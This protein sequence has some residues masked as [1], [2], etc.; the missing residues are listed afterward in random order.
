[1]TAPFHGTK[2]ALCIALSFSIYS[3]PYAAFA[4]PVTGQSSFGGGSTTATSSPSTSTSGGSPFG[5][6]SSISTGKPS[7]GATGDSPFG[8]SGS[9]SGTS[10]PP[11]PADQAPI[12]GGTPSTATS[13]PPATS[14]NAP[15][16]GAQTPGT[17][18][19]P[20]ASTVRND[21]VGDLK[22]QVDFAQTHVVAS[23]RRIF[24]PFLV[25]GKEA[26]VLFT[27][28]SSLAGVNLVVELDG[29]RHEFRMN[30]PSDMPRTARFDVSHTYSGEYVKGEYAAYRANAFSFQIPW[31]LFHARARISFE[32]VGGKGAPIKAPG[33]EEY[34]RR[35]SL[36]SEHFVFMQ[37]ESEGL[38]LM[39]I[40]GCVFK[41]ENECDVDV[42]QFDQ[43]LNPELAKLAAREMFSYLPVQRLHLG[44]GKAYWPYAVAL[45]PDSKPHVYNASNWSSWAEHGDVTLP[46]KLGMGAYWR[47]ASDLANKAEG[48]YVA[49]TGSMLDGPAGMNMLPPGV[50]ASCNGSSCHYPSRPHGFW[51]ETGHGLG[52]PHDTPGRYEDWAYRGYDH[53]L[54]PNVYPDAVKQGWPVDHLGNY[55]FGHPLGYLSDAHWATGTASAPLIDEFESLRRWNANKAAAWNTYVVPYT[56]QQ[57][58]KVQQRFGSFPAGVAF[59]GPGDDHRPS[60]GSSHDNSV[61]GGKKAHSG[62]IRTASMELLQSGAAPTRTGVPIH[63]IVATFSDPSH[64]AD[65]INQIYPAIVSNYGDV[66]DLSDL[67]HAARSRSASGHQDN[68]SS[69]QYL[70]SLD[71]TC[72]IQQGSQAKRGDCLSSEA[73]L[74]FEELQISDSSE[75]SMGPILAI[76]GQDGQCLNNALAFV[77]CHTGDRTMQW[78]GRTDITGD[79][80]ALKLQNP[81]NGL[82]MTPAGSDAF[83][84]QANSD[85]NLM[86]RVDVGSQLPFHRYE[87]KVDYQGG[88]SENVVLYDGVMKKDDLVSRAVN[89]DSGRKP[90]KVALLVDGKQ[91]FERAL[92]ANDLPPAI[93]V[94]AEFGYPAA[95]EL[96][97]MKWLRSS[98]TGHC[99]RTQSNRLVQG[100]CDVRASWR[101]KGVG[102]HDA[103]LDTVELKAASGDCLRYNMVLGTCAGK[104]DD[105][106]WLTRTDL[107]G[108]EGKVYLQGAR[109]G[110]FLSASMDGTLSLADLHAATGQVFESVT[111]GVASWLRSRETGKC[112]GVSGG[113]MVQGRCDS[114]ANKW[115]IIDDVAQG[116]SFILMSTGQQCVDHQLSAKTCARADEASYQWRGRADLTQSDRVTRLQ[117]GVLGRFVTA[118]GSG[119]VT[120]GGLANGAGQEFERLGLADVAQ[121]YQ[122][123]S[124]QSGKCLAR[125]EN[126]LTLGTCAG[127]PSVWNVL[128]REHEDAGTSLFALV[129]RGNSQCLSGDLSM[130]AC[131]DDNRLNWRGREDLTGSDTRIKLQAW[132]HGT[133]VT[134]NE[135]GEISL[136]G[137]WGSTNQHFDLV[138]LP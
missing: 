5:G 63:T 121:A 106:Q 136:E 81:V 46:A 88:A 129:D 117:D 133:F 3:H 89:L 82:F 124:V 131:S 127:E 83:E 35:G 24:D 42:A 71:G 103:V 69:D 7:A 76:K 41:P 108:S 52:L 37:Q 21:L 92:E 123:R 110:K 11:K 13:K 67:T 128:K 111:P 122:L 10:K 99:L 12:G 77:T 84:M 135:S 130:K 14:N 53:T 59:A 51:H 72:L 113:V 54:V 55:Y 32:E 8:G 38:V 104:L 134:V 85:G 34:V 91:V 101:V 125:G 17:T 70:L 74:N 64:N 98:S 16:G 86:L 100:S 102:A 79:H 87:L 45:G 109:E 97:P 22:G 112:L 40:K 132:E 96:L 28:E 1:M 116:A 30:D 23:K 66:F 78:R 4:K 27:P 26:L 61:T 58:L 56:H 20:A 19:P 105:R 118:L 114:F 137:N 36:P 15:I 120:M 25:P 50:A 115:Q 6:G 31:N 73:V 126:G 94:G 60:S 9:S 138:P 43:E 107:T 47:Q 44:T 48:R 65:G 2:R 90:S 18:K 93:H 119:K 80:A 57:T 29:T 39:N 62:D 33:S 68:R 49:I 95:D 75:A